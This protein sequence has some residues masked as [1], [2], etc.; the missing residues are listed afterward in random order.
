MRR[1]R[2]PARRAP[3][4]MNYQTQYTPCH[5][6]PLTPSSHPESPPTRPTSPWRTIP[7]PITRRQLRLI[8][9]PP[10]PHFPA[11]HQ[12]HFPLFYRVFRV[13]MG[14]W[15]GPL[16]AP[17]PSPADPLFGGCSQPARLPCP[18]ARE[19]RTGRLG[20][21]LT[22]PPGGFGGAVGADILSPQAPKLPF[23][24]VFDPSVRTYVDSPKTVFCVFPGDLITFLGGLFLR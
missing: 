24:A 15:H 18:T 1:A 13:G 19:A 10:A 17:S 8:T 12:A 11:L 4:R 7:N 3:A 16:A 21:F 14:R 20:A 6:N 22:G 9:L 5:D 23:R 2:A